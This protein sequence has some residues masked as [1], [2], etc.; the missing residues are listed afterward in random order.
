[1]IYS[2]TG[3]AVGATPPDPGC[4]FHL[5]DEYSEEMDR[6]GRFIWRHHI[7]GLVQERRNSS[8]V[9]MELRFSCIEP[10]IYAFTQWGNHESS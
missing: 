10:S 9:A 8:A 7:G 4:L 3:I 6:N 5:M 1:M 2:R